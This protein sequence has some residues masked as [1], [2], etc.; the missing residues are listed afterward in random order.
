[1]KALLPFALLLLCGCDDTPG[2]WSAIVYADAQ[3]RS[4]YLTT[5]GFKSLG[6]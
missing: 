3:D 5:H 4:H 1:M 6:M 2:Q